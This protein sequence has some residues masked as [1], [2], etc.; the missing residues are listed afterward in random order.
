MTPEGR[1][2]PPYL[3]VLQEV[4]SLSRNISFPSLWLFSSEGSS[5]DEMGER[6][7]KKDKIVFSI[8]FFNFFHRTCGSAVN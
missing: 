6:G 2:I 8:F 7:T 5:A 1:F 3:F 4:L